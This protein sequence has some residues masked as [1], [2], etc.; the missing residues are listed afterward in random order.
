VEA[1][2]S[3][4]LA[5]SESGFEGLLDEIQESLRAKTYNRAQ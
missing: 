2:R 5:K 3:N 4:R 1:D